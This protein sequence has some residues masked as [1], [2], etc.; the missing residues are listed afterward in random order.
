M[1]LTGFGQQSFS[2]E[3]GL[4]NT[5][6]KVTGAVD[7]IRVSFQLLFYRLRSG[8][9][10]KLMD[11]SELPRGLSLVRE[12]CAHQLLVVYPAQSCR[13]VFPQPSTRLTRHN[14]H[15]TCL[16]TPVHFNQLL[17]PRTAHPCPVQMLQQMELVLHQAWP[18]WGQRS[19]NLIR[20][21]CEQYGT[22]VCGSQP[23]TKQ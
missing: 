20:R 16:P 18:M 15:H 17:P 9:G 12:E 4:P 3:T 23:G 1:V 6:V 8:P 10:L 22:G 19:P 2:L 13:D 7:A 14:T 5:L 11:S 21:A